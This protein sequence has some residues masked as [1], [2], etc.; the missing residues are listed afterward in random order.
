[1]DR[2]AIAL[3]AFAA[4]VVFAARAAFCALAR[5]RDFA[6]AAAALVGF[7]TVFADDFF[8]IVHFPPRR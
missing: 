4:V 5:W 3:G 6:A 8:A 7:L 1:V 2:L